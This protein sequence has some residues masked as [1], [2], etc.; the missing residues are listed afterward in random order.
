M[1]LKNTFR[2]RVGRQLFLRFMVAALLPIVGLSIYAYVSVSQI[3]VTA[4]HNQM[5]QAS[6][7][8]GMSVIDRLNLQ[9][10]KLERLAA[11]GSL[12]GR[13]G[14]GAGQFA[15]PAATISF[16]SL[17]SAGAKLLRH[18]DALLRLAPG[19]TPHLELVA[20]RPKGSRLVATRIENSQLWDNDIAPAH[21]CVLTH[22]LKTL[23]C[24][25]S[26]RS[27]SVVPALKPVL[28]GAGT[29]IFNYRT[30]RRDY[31]AGFWEVSLEPSFGNRGL[32]FVVMQ[33]RARAL[34]ALTDFKL[35]FGAIALLALGIAAWLA[36]DQIRRQLRPLGSLMDSTQKLAKG[37]FSTTAEVRG[38]DEFAGLSRAF[39]GM[40]VN[41][42]DKFRLLSA[43]ARLDREILGASLMQDVIH[44]LLSGVHEV[45][46]EASAFVVHADPSGH[47]AIYSAQRMYTMSRQEGDRLRAEY[48]APRTAPWHKL[49]E[50]HPIRGRLADAGFHVGNYILAFPA[51][52]DKRCI[53]ELVLGFQRE[54]E[55][56]DDI[57]HAARALTDRLTVA[58]A[59]LAA[60]DAL[61][62][63]A[64][65]DAL[66]NLPNRVL[67]RDRAEQALERSW[68]NGT[69][70]ALML[71][72]FDK[73]KEINDA[74][75][76]AA[77]DRLLEICSGRL[78]QCVRGSDTVARFGGDEFIILL[79]DLEPN[80]AV[81][82]TARIAE[83]LNAALSEPVDIQGIPV[84]TVASIGI[85]LYPNNAAGFEDLLRMADAAMYEAKR[86]P[87][88][89]FCFYSQSMNVATR[90]RFQLSQE[91]RSA[92]D[93]G[94]MVLYYQ[95]RLDMR[96]HRIV[97]AEA[98]VR[99]L[100]PTRGLVEPDAFVSQLDEMGLGNRLGDWVLNEA[101]RQMARWDVADLPE[102]P[103]S[104]N[105]SPTQ[106]RVQNLQSQIEHCLKYHKLSPHRLEIEMLEAT[107]VDD[108]EVVK[109]NLT[110][111]REMGINIALD[112]FG[113]GYSSLFYLTRV[114]ANVLKLDRAFILDLATDS[115]QQAIVEQIIGLAKALGFT[116]V[117]EGIEEE[118]QLEILT[119][120]DCDQFQ[121]YL[122]R[123]PIPADAFAELVRSQ[124]AAD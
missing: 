37:D 107:A 19:E 27:P 18:G 112:D 71:A 16:A 66:T 43:L 51:F 5:R 4:A 22:S 31:L 82:S 58:A 67:L 73:F 80:T 57:V 10:K 2:S 95:P 89:V 21:F 84:T 117:A 49:P 121:G 40:A 65:H 103:I 62:H 63:Q 45:I 86:T 77:G 28:T 93:N 92:I 64:H 96:T 115:R 120:M 39:N 123:R 98:L 8:L 91:L 60:E 41:L 6:R 70:V 79:P 113:T 9:A 87:G 72:D 108:S 106:F 88:L 38:E 111:L 35:F 46:P 42:R 13:D 68:R 105:L 99:W 85:S 122:F 110:A 7:T 3:L 48:S 17:G 47:C 25:P 24:S 101:C 100:S 90:Q 12:P 124:S 53:G 11:S 76:H 78:E 56:Q 81:R 26:L 74:L 109:E 23:Y 83:N 119:T 97:G 75:G 1:R 36:I 104:I 61:L 50:G 29:G 14:D 59:K 54:P 52:H 55:S 114:P 34:Q 32:I 44:T 116:V 33:G 20:M 69:V 102:V 94:E 118:S 30:D 15:T